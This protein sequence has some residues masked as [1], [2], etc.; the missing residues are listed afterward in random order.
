MDIDTPPNPPLET[1]AAIGEIAKTAGDM[2]Q[3]LAEHW[4]HPRADF[5]AHVID[6]HLAVAHIVTNSGDDQVD[7]TTWRTQ[8]QHVCDLHLDAAVYLMACS[9][10]NGATAAA[11]AVSDGASCVRQIL[12]IE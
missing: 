11:Q 4:A 7:M 3:M 6:L 12:D 10:G 2:M 5:A 9:Y 8:F 1:L